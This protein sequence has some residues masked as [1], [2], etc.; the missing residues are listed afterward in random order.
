[1]NENIGREISR[2]KSFSETALVQGVLTGAPFV[3]FGT[4]RS[5][6]TTTSFVNFCA[7]GSRGRVEL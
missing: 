4:K 5:K 7:E 2:S 3:L 1:M 6:F